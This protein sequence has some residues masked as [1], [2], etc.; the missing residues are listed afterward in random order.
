MRVKEL[1]LTIASFIVGLL[2]ILVMVNAII[3]GGLERVNNVNESEVVNRYTEG[4]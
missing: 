2:L 1:A 4:H 3:N